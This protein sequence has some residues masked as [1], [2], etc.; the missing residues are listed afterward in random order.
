MII[1]QVTNKILIVFFL[2]EEILLDT[3]ISSIST[4]FK[5]IG[6]KFIFFNFNI[7]KR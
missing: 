4:A 6:D 7:A 5:K 2:P 3:N 1:I